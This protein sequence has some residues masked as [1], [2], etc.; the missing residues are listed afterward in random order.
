VQQRY[1]APEK[2]TGDVAAAK[3]SPPL[4][5]DRLE[6]EALFRAGPAAG[7]AADAVAGIFDF[8]EHLGG[9]VFVQLFESQDVVDADLVAAAAADAGLL[10]D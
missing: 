7:L 3:K 9:I 5:Y 4:E 10:I 2:E 8:H 1:A 6:G